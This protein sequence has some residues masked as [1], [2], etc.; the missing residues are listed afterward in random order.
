MPGMIL[1]ALME[2][3]I[4]AASLLAA[5]LYDIRSG[6]SKMESAGADWLHFDVMD[7]R[8]VP[9]LTFGPKMAAD[10]KPRT[11]LPLDVHL[12]TVE[13]ERLVPAFVDAGADHI[14]FHLE[15]AIHAH[16]LV[17]SIRASGAKAGVSIV[18]STPVSLL[19][20]LLPFVDLVLVMTVDPGAG[21][22]ALIPS[23][24]QKCAALAAERKE[25]GLSFRISVDGGINQKTAGQAGA[26]GADILVMGSAL[27][28][29]P[30]P[31]A[32]LRATRDSFKAARR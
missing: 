11:S 25:R 10:L 6:L 9:G 5:D 22:Q 7:G 23:C 15:A 12:M 19:S 14:T 18:P 31:A 16:R 27:F 29:A 24:L 4:I 30:D 21:G 8:F 17:E 2:E 13:P 20:E 32:F 28:S 1:Y 3:P 26:A